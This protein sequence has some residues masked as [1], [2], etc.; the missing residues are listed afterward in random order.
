MHD[1]NF[2]E[3]LLPI[4]KLNPA[5]I[6]LRDDI[7]AS[8][9]Y[10]AVK[11]ARQNARAAEIKFLQQESDNTGSQEWRDVQAKAIDILKVQSK[12]IEIMVWLIEAL[13]RTNNFTG[14]TAGFDLAKQLIETFWESLFPEADEDGLESKIAAFTGLNGDDAPGSLIQPIKSIS[15]TQGKKAGPFALWHYQQAL[16][17]EKITNIQKREQRI[18][19]LGFSLTDILL[20]VN[21]SGTEFY[22]NLLRQV[23]TCE[24][25][26][27]SLDALLTE[28]C[29][30]EAPP[31]SFIR[32][33]LSEVKE[34][35]HF[36]LQDAPFKNEVLL[37]T[38]SAELETGKEDN[39]VAIEKEKTIK[40]QITVSTNGIIK[41]RL[42]ALQILSKVANYFSDKEPHSPIPFLL[43]RAIRWGN[44]PLPDL[45][46]EL[47]SENAAKADVEKLTGINLTD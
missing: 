47:I 11:D 27:D 10:Y 31:S 38:T 14:L 32:N 18:K 28:K 41:S 43:N 46:K 39:T 24:N 6:N 37:S 20:A 33:T 42:E 35:I 44:T 17:I 30:H 45:L 16:E 7:S 19:E 9:V 25:S 22:E 4:D 5:G 26:F 21:E 8:T 15:I 29:L 40:S 2:E 12:D 13:L 36:L 34:H 3:L 1:L 23:E